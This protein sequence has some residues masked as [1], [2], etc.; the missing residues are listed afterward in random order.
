MP[1][2]SSVAAV[3]GLLG[4][5]AAL[6]WLAS[7]RQDVAPTREVDTR[8]PPESRVVTRPATPKAAEDRLP[9]EKEGNV[10]RRSQAH[11]T[12]TSSSGL[13]AQ[14]SGD[15]P[16]E[17]ASDSR[18]D[19]IGAKAQ[20]EPYGGAPEAPIMERN[21]EDHPTA[22]CT[23]TWCWSGAA[24]IEVMRAEVTAGQFGQ[25]IAD[26]HCRAVGLGK[27]DGCTLWKPERQDLPMNC[28]NYDA[29]ADYCRWQHAR[30]PL[31]DEW[32]A[33]YRARG[34]Y[35]WGDDDPSPSRVAEGPGLGKP[36]GSETGLPDPPCSHPEGRS[37]SGLCDMVGNLAEWTG[38]PA[39][40]A[41][42]PT[43]PLIVVGYAYD[44]LLH[45]VQVGRGSANEYTGFR[46]ARDRATVGKDAGN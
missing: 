6:L 38:D 20:A 44:S 27:A 19:V 12:G 16:D 4:G 41:A 5:L 24:G 43:T 11:L 28:L 7:G 26:G 2:V 45:D 42:P 15:Q 36:S 1:K 13:V 46:C 34:K 10:E 39:P 33:E 17:R 8:Q 23:D 29:A 37:E 9:A 14:G 18:N 31:L 21:T 22:E 30:L 3:I 40:G 35:P 32:Y 25:C